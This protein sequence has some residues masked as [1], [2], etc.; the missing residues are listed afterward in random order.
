VDDDDPRRADP[1]PD[2]ARRRV[3]EL[4]VATSRADEGG[5]T[6]VGG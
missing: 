5:R 6:E 1:E 4:A 2:G 3:V